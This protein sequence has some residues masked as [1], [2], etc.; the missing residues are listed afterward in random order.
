M[1]TQAKLEA[2]TKE[3][4]ERV[5]TRALAA[6]DLEIRGGEVTLLLGPSGSGKTTLLNLLGGLD[7]P[8]AGKVIALGRDLST[9]SR[10][11]LTLFR[12]E[13]VGFVF[14]FFN[15]VPTLTASENV[16]VAAELAGAGRNEARA[17]LTRVGLAGL[18]D[19]FPSELSGGQQQRVAIARA[20]AKRPRLLFADEPTGALDHE[21]GAQVVRLIIDAARSGDCAVVVVTHDESLS[22]SAD[23][24]VRLRDG[25]VTS[26]RRTRDAEAAS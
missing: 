9:L 16:Q 14:Q 2:A 4:G 26:D 19:R 13:N 24:V 21:A 18:E 5:R 11:G 3:Y 17:W 12:R 7:K 10:R 6:V 1:T 15:L 22:E 8:T 20:L 25:R 23:R